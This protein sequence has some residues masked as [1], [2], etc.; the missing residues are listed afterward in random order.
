MHPEYE[1]QEQFKSS[2]LFCSVS[3]FVLQYLLFFSFPNKSYDE[4]K[5]EIVKDLNNKQSEHPPHL[6][7]PITLNLFKDPVITVSISILIHLAF[8][9]MKIARS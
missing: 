9:K 7:C 5:K 8:Y 1:I 4:V 3:L 2:V 6:V